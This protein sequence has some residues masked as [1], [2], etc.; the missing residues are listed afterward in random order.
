MGGEGKACEDRSVKGGKEYRE[1]TRINETNSQ[2]KGETE[3]GTIAGR[4]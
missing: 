1:T 2:K 3:N 4:K